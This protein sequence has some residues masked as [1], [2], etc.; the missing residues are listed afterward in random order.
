MW[1]AWCGETV[2]TPIREHGVPFHEFCRWKRQK[3]TDRAGHSAVHVQGAI[4]NRM[5]IETAIRQAA[6]AGWDVLEYQDR[7]EV[8][9]A[10]LLAGH[11]WGMTQNGEDGHG[12]PL[13]TVL[14]DPSFWRALGQARRWGA[15]E[16][17]EHWHQLITELADGRSVE[18]FFEALR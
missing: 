11:V 12:V 2:D 13:A 3:I 1:C 4:L 8:D 7:I 15:D 10:D 16:W 17:R 14:L 18:D 6:E 5:T 9:T